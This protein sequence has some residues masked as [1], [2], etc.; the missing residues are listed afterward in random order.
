MDYHIH[1]ENKEYQAGKF[2]SSARM[3]GVCQLLLTFFLWTPVCI[4]K[5][6]TLDFIEKSCVCGFI[7]TIGV[8]GFEPVK[9]IFEECPFS[10]IS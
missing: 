4:K 7:D 6:Q 9:H 2:T 3:P 5:P 8:T 10:A 1:M